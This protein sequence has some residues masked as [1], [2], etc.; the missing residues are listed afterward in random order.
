MPLPEL[1]PGPLLGL[2]SPL[3]PELFP[4]PLFGLSPLSPG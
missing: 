1:F 4:E 3:L 2:L